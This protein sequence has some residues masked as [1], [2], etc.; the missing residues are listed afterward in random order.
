MTKGVAPFT[1]FGGKGRLY[2][3]IL[4][5]FPAHRVYVEVFGGAASCLFAKAPA[6]IEVYNDIDRGLVTLFRVLRD[7]AQF[8]EFMFKVSHVLYSRQEYLD[9]R[10]TWAAM[11]RDVDKAVAFYTVARQCFSGDFGAGWSRTRTDSVAGMARGPR[12]WLGGIDRLPTIHERMQRVQ[13]ECLDFRE[14][15][16]AYDTADTLFYLDPPYIPATR[17]SGTYSHELSAEDHAEL[18]TRLL[19]LKGMAVLSGY[20]HPLY[21]PLETAGWTRV[22][23]DSYAYA[24]GTGAGQKEHRTE[25]LWISPN[26]TKQLRLAE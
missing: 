21:G 8:G 1:W 25:C 18:V 19:A 23:F 13:V 15:L 22:E 11:E 12:R 7:P 14:L 20:A 6:P 16:T 2:D 9:A 24:A 17:K 4:P 3:K 26:A 10:A 5:H